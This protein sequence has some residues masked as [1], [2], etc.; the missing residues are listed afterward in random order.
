MSPDKNNSRLNYPPFVSIWK[1][2]R[3]KLAFSNLQF[4]TTSSLRERKALLKVYKLSFSEKMEFV[5]VN[6]ES[7]ATKNN[8]TD[9]PIKKEILFFGTRKLFMIFIESIVI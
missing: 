3:K 2:G 1:V 6:L 4:V 5:R 7:A 9:E 8:P